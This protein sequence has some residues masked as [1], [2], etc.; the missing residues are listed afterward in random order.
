MVYYT[1]YN[2]L[3]TFFNYPKLTFMNTSNNI[4]LDSKKTN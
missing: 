3:S 2:Y 4:Y 1:I